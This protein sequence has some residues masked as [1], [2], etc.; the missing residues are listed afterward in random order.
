MA[1]IK[2]QNTALLDLGTSDIIQ[3]DVSYK[4]K[5]ML[6][7]KGLLSNSTYRS[8]NGFLSTTGKQIRNNNNNVTI[9]DREYT[10]GAPFVSSNTEIDANY[11]LA[12]TSNYS[13]SM[14]VMWAEQAPDNNLIFKTNRTSTSYP[15]NFVYEKMSAIALGDLS[16]FAGIT[17]TGYLHI[18]YWKYTNSNPD[19][20]LSYALPSN[21]TSRLSLLRDI[22]IAQVSMYNIAIGID[23]T[24]MQSRYTYVYTVATNRTVDSQGVYNYTT[25]TPL[26]VDTIHGFGCV[27]EDGKLLT[28]EPLP[29]Q[30]LSSD[31]SDI[32]SSIKFF[33]HAR[34]SNFDY[35]NVYSFTYDS[36]VNTATVVSS[37]NQYDVTV[38]D[39]DILQYEKVKASQ[40]NVSY[41]S[42]SDNTVKTTSSSW[43]DSIKGLGASSLSVGNAQEGSNLDWFK[44]SITFM[45]ANA[46]NDVQLAYGIYAYWNNLGPDSAAYGSPV[47]VFMRAQWA[48][49]IGAGSS[50]TVDSGRATTFVGYI[51]T[52]NP[53]GQV[54]K[55]A[56]ANDGLQI[57]PHYRFFF[58]SADDKGKTWDYGRGW[59]RFLYGSFVVQDRN[60]VGFQIMENP[61]QLITVDGTCPEIEGSLSSFSEK[62]KSQTMDALLGINVIPRQRTTDVNSSYSGSTKNIEVTNAWIPEGESSL[63]I[64]PT[65]FYKYRNYVATPGGSKLEYL[66]LGRFHGITE[67]TISSTSWY[68]GHTMG[69][70]EITGISELPFRTIFNTRN[71]KAQVIYYDNSPI[72]I[73]YNTTLLFTPRDLSGDYV[74]YSI[75][76][77]GSYANASDTEAS[78]IVWDNGKIQAIQLSKGV[79]SFRIEKMADYIFKTNSCQ[80]S[81]NVFSET[82]GGNITQATAFISYSM[83]CK[84][85]LS[86]LGYWLLM[87][88][89]GPSYGTNNV[90]YFGAGIN[91]NLDP[92]EISTSFLLPSITIPFYS[93]TSDLATLQSI[94][95]QS[96]KGLITAVVEE[97]GFTFIPSVCNVDQYWTFSQ[98]STDNTYKVSIDSNNKR[99]FDDTLEDTS[100]WPDAATTIY[101]IGI[102]SKT[103]GENYITATVDTGNNYVSRFYNQNNKTFLAYN[104]ASQVYYG[105]EI[106]TIQSGN[107]YFDGQGIYYLGSQSDYSQN[108]FTA[109]AIGMKFL[110]NSS[111]EAYFYSEWDK[112][113][114]LYTASN[115]LQK[116]ISL[117]D[118]GNIIDALYSS[119]EQAL[120]ILFDDKKI[121]IKTQVDDCFIDGID[122]GI[123][124]GAY[125][126]STEIG[127]QEIAITS[128][129]TKVFQIMNP[130]RFDIIRPFEIETEWIGNS[131]VV[132]SFHYADIIFYSDNPTSAI[133]VDIYLNTL[134]GDVVKEKKRT[135]TI[136]PS[137]WK[138]KLYRE[139]IVPAEPIGNAAKLIITSSDSIKVMSM[140]L[141]TEKKSELPSAPRAGRV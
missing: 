52:Y 90:Y 28:G 51:D 98:Y 18:W 89:D 62:F 3:S 110:A 41:F 108:I 93:A 111:S 128:A 112:S 5:N 87:P 118:C 7:Y 96:R 92:N 42:I 30:C 83:D 38:L 84:F 121:Y 81:N 36:I 101:P 17:N 127:C 73:A 80:N 63:V 64:E 35:N 117:A 15:T 123:Y 19:Y 77:R 12:A 140:T 40:S 86:N 1:N 25:R 53:M 59:A 9:G 100:W 99:Y 107:Y 124:Y 46:S 91:P 57:F 125:L 21:I 27:S 33:P 60:N 55:N 54:G 103:Y 137:M 58:N 26:L 131:D 114:Y 65:T 44:Q 102:A 37:A 109:Y 24:A 67:N 113:L 139:R 23:S 45:K 47:F 72:A 34:V 74:G 78:F 130:Y 129:G 14:R 2:I 106:F 8:G 10:L 29:V 22:T 75:N 49:Q 95:L 43:V 119:A 6:Q 76:H 104:N 71:G 13:G 79:Y 20:V 4:R 105:S 48:T 122:T 68:W 11:V 88:T 56:L 97:D 115:T 39:N 82:H 94:V 116:S 32:L 16:I 141:A 132:T 50:T 120:Y 85:T 136:K 31:P 135:L 66:S 133:T 126:Q 138:N 70:L 134:N 61:M 69:S